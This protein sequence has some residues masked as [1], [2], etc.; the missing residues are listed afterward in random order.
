MLVYLFICTNK[1]AYACYNVTYEIEGM[2]DQKGFIRVN[3]S[4]VVNK[5]QIKEIRP[6]LN[7]KFQ[8]LMKNG[9]KVDVTRSYYQKFKENIGF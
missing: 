1:V 3:K 2:Y 9:R 4:V 5:N 6:K 8:L 7:T